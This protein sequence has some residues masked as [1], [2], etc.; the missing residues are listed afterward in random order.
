M[1]RACFDLGDYAEAIR[2]ARESLLLLAGSD[3][4]DALLLVACSQSRLGL[5]KQS[6]D[7]LSDIGSFVDALPAESRSKFFGQRAFA[8]SKLGRADKA[9]DDLT[10][11]RF[12]AEEDNDQESVARVRNNLAKQY[13]EAGRFEEALVEVG[14]AIEFAKT[15]GDEILLGDFYDMKSQVLIDAGRF[16]E[17]LIF[18]EHALVL[19]ADHPSITEAKETYG[20]ALI[21]LGVT[22]L[23]QKDPIATFAAKRRASDL[24][25]CTLDENIVHLA[26]ERSNGHVS[27]AAS[28]L[29]VNHKAIIKFASKH[30]SNRI[31]AVRRLKSIIKEK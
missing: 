26:L 15:L 13:K 7:T 28:D 31:P 25:K 19:L 16:S 29:N 8:Y 27:Q 3:R 10:A 20:R 30:G 1:A 18:S 2:L 4:F 17:A 14:A 5:L 24:V 12:W 22:Y 11:A 23:E 21:G 9:L 6:L